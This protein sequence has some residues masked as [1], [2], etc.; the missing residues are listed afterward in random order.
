VEACDLITNVELIFNTMM[1]MMM[2]MMHDDAR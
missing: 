1:M 2:M